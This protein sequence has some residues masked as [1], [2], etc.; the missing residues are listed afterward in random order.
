MNRSEL[1]KRLSVLLTAACVLSV[2]PTP[3]FAAELS[4]VDIADAVVV[5]ADAT[6]AFSDD[7]L[8]DEPVAEEFVAEDVL[9]EEPA[10][11]ASSAL[12]DDVL[13]IGDGNDTVSP[14]VVPPVSGDKVP[15]VSVSKVAG[16]QK[17]D[18]KAIAKEAGISG[19]FVKYTVADKD[20]KKLVKV[21]KNGI[22]TTKAPK[23]GS[24]WATINA[25]TDKKKGAAVAATFKIYVSV[26]K[27]VPTNAKGKPV[28]TV[29]LI[30]RN[31]TLSFDGMFEC[32]DDKGN[33]IDPVLVE[34]TDKKGNFDFN[35]DTYDIKFKGAKNSGSAKI[36][37]YYG[38]KASDK[39]SKKLCA[40]YTFT[41][42]AKVPKIKSTFVVKEGKTKVLKLSALPKSGVTV[43]WNVYNVSDNKIV[44][45]NKLSANEIIKVEEVTNKKGVKAS[46]KITGLKEGSIA[47]VPEINGYTDWKG[48]ACIVTVKKK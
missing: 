17:I 5:E 40:K 44:S 46:A 3:A 10:A 25:Y 36:T 7:A 2:I 30:D 8:V 48:Y 32:K 42:K 31:T 41:V 33:K 34:V 6:E 13:V 21:N 18:L 4:D 14:D 47:V 1:K 26:V 20:S 16:K 29:T 27:Y 28:K 37:V 15:T 45:E 24:G 43:S 11:E 9:E 23:T 39:A 19:N 35:K 22:V 38:E 12:V